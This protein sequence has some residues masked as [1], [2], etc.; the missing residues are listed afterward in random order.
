MWAL[1]HW[2]NAAL[3]H[4]HKWKL[5]TFHPSSTA[6]DVPPQHVIEA[7]R[8]SEG[9]AAPVLPDDAL[10]AAETAA[11][12]A[13]AKAKAKAKPAAKR[14]GKAKARPSPF[15]SSSGS[16]SSFS[17]TPGGSASANSSSTSSSSD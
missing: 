2:C 9:P 5:A 1:R 3:Q 4:D 6:A 16:G 7:Q 14:K 15:A 10:D 11:A 12:K 17:C 8:I 13:H